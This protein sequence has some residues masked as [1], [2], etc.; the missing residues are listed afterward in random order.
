M[1]TTGRLTR[2][3]I[4][5]GF[6]ALSGFYMG[7]TGVKRVLESGVDVTAGGY[8]LFGLC[9]FALCVLTF[10]HPDH[11]PD[12]RE[13]VHWLVEAVVVFA[14]VFVGATGMRVLFA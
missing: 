3:Q 10:T 1:T 9:G 14:L 13:K 12:G 6:W 7:G 4:F 11:V 8:L 5:A 2:A